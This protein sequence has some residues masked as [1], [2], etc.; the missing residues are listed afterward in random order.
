MPLS[1]TVSKKRISNRGR[2]QLICKYNP[3]SGSKLT[4]DFKAYECI[5]EGMHR[6]YRTEKGWN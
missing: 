4:Q 1:Y 6:G 5:R 3:A 2:L